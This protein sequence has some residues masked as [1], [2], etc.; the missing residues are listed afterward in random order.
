MATWVGAVIAGL[1]SGPA[2]QFH[3]AGLAYARRAY[4]DNDGDM[5]RDGHRAENL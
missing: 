2:T 3:V 5:G 4:Q 1:I